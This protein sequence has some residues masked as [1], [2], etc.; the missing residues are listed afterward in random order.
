MAGQELTSNL[1]VWELEIAAQ[2]YQIR[3]QK[4]QKAHKLD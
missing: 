4:A 2:E 1:G 3:P